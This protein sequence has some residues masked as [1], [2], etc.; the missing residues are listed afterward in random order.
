MTNTKFS[1]FTFFQITRRALA[2]ALLALVLGLSGARAESA[3]DIAR[4]A[5]EMEKTFM[6]RRSNLSH[7]M[8]LTEEMLDASGKVM[9]SEKKTERVK[10]QMKS[11]YVDV[12]KAENAAPSTAD[13]GMPASAPKPAKKGGAGGSFHLFA[14]YG[15]LYPRFDYVMDGKETVSGV[16]CYRIKYSPK[17]GQQPAK[18]REEK[19]LN[20]MCGTMWISI[21]DGSGK[22]HAIVRNEAELPAPVQLAWVFASAEQ[23]KVSYRATK[24]PNGDFGPSRIS[25]F[26]RISV[27]FG[28]MS[29]RQVRTF[30][31]WT[32]LK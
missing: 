3:S 10:G 25:L 12:N 17:A 32:L 27:P 4:T 11:S 28:T 19:V 1:S 29:S 2:V 31:D 20:R 15:A 16:P 30:T 18:S 24:L 5:A 21:G 14:D 23:V 8:S 26:Y 22:D 7:T 6:E 9:K 13:G